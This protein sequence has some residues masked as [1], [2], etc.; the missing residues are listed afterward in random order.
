LIKVSGAT[1][2]VSSLSKVS[3][4]AFLKYENIRYKHISLFQL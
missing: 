2:I 1:S 3:G 4:I